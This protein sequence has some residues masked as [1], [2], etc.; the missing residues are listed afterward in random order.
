MVH[1]FRSVRTTNLIVWF[2]KSKRLGDFF[3]R[4]ASMTRRKWCSRS[5]VGSQSTY[6]SGGDLVGGF[7]KERV[8]Y[9]ESSTPTVLLKDAGRSCRKGSLPLWN[10]MVIIKADGYM[11][12]FLGPALFTRWEFST[13]NEKLIF[14]EGLK[15]RKRLKQPPI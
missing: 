9:C 10:I 4:E 8:R 11:T 3:V 2:R 5:M 13:K 1:K 6:F 14:H 15:H 7:R 12:G